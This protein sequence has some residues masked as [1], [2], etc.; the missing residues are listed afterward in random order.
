MNF[1]LP[2]F[3]ERNLVTT[4]KGPCFRLAVSFAQTKLDFDPSLTSLSNTVPLEIEKKSHCKQKQRPE[5][6]RM[7]LTCSR[8]HQHHQTTHRLEELPHPAPAVLAHLRQPQRPHRGHL[9]RRPRRHPQGR[10]LRLQGPPRDPGRGRAERRRR[11]G[12]AAPPRPEQPCHLGQP[13]GGEAQ[14][15]LAQGRPRPRHPAPSQDGERV[16]PGVRVLGLRAQRLVRRRM[17][18]TIQVKRQNTIRPE[19]LELLV[20]ALIAYILSDLRPDWF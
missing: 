6:T 16:R 8:R 13:C 10:L 11:S 15:A 9:R 4:W 14:A 17:R 1:E 3:R 12:E 2:S 18:G 20:I 19:N 7:F 5:L